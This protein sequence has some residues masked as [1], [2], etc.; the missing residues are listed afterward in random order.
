LDKQLR[1][2][3]IAQHYAPEDV[4]GAVLGTELATD[5]VK[6]GHQ[7]TFLTCAPNYPLGKIFP[8]YKN[9]IFS[10]ETIDGV[11]IIRVWSYISKKS[12]WRRILNYGTFSVSA[13][14]GGLLSGK[15]DLVLSFSPPL[16]L[17]ISA[18][19]LSRIK[20]TPWILNVMDIYPEIAILSGILK[21]PIAIKI[22]TGLEKFIY[23]QASHIQV[24]SEGFKNNLVK[25]GVSPEKISTI[26]VWADPDLIHPETKSNSFSKEYNLEEKFVI[27]YS[28][29]LGVNTSLEDVIIAADYLKFQKDIY[30]VFVGE[31]TKKEELVAQVRQKYL[32]NVLFLPFQPRGLFNLV[33]ASASVSLVS[34]SANAHYTSLPSKTFN[35]MA[36]NRPI[37]AVTPLESE[38]AHLIQNYECGIVIPPGNPEYLSEAILTLKS[39]PA[40]LDQ[41]GNNGRQ[42]L[43]EN[44]SRNH[45]VDLYE[46]L[47]FQVLN[48]SVSSNI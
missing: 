8:G 24:L 45:C 11:R 32:D 14:W 29:N 10:I 41:L 27:L 25:K 9:R 46:K 43:I 20:K 47:F 19:L 28:G 34:L 5:L 7:V 30:F 23:H 2:L 17:G 1:I 44:Y 48:R 42:K 12:F 21:N 38:I 18:W 37:L 4:S 39:D 26:P 35:I 6:R 33:L 13:F 40:K 22:F 3:I 36:S 16:P 31:G 15:Q